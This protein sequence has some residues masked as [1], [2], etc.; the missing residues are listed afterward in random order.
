MKIKT[1]VCQRR[2]GYHLYLFDA[3]IRFEREADERISFKTAITPSSYERVILPVFQ[4]TN[5]QRRMRESQ[6]QLI[7]FETYYHVSVPRIRVASRVFRKR[8]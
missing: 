4:F 2:D 8:E 5:E 1:E 3:A 6:N 7:V